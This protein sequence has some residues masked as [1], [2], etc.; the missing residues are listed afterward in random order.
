MYFS[1]ARIIT[2]NNESAFI[3]CNYG[4]GVYKNH[5]ELTNKIMDSLKLV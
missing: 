5:K 3:E 1:G 4:Q 2:E